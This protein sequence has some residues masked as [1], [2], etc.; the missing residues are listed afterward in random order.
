MPS[1]E[2]PDSD[3][4]KS[5]DSIDKDLA[6]ANNRDSIGND[7]D[8]KSVVGII[9]KNRVSSGRN[10]A[11]NRDSVNGSRNATKKNTV[12]SGDLSSDD[13]KTPVKRH[14]GKKVPPIRTTTL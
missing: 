1:L 4:A 14:N 3:S 5:K 12:S 2:L 7:P 13:E 11:E 8:K 6:K 10:V 9:G